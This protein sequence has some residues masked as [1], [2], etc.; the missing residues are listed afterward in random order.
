MISQAWNNGAGSGL[1]TWE[2]IATDRTAGPFGDAERVQQRVGHAHGLVRHDAPGH[3]RRIQRIQQLIQAGEYDRTDAYGCLVAFQVVE[4]KPLMLICRYVR[5]RPGRSAPR[6]RGT[7]RS[8]PG[9]SPAA[10]RLRRAA[11]P[12]RTPTMS[13]AVSIS[14]PSRSNSTAENDGFQRHLNARPVA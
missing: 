13:G 6:R 4:S 11:G 8:G 10:G 1:R 3:A 7:R 12:A 9:R 2:G 5:E 14:V